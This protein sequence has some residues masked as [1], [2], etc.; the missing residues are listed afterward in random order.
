MRVWVRTQE[1]LAVAES[2]KMNMCGD[3]RRERMGV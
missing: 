3:L 1:G 2:G